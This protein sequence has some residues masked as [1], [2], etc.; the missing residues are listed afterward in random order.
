MLQ[1]CGHWEMVFGVGRTYCLLPRGHE[2][3]HKY[4]SP[5]EVRSRE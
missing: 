4:K 2:G 5:E 1:R 3:E